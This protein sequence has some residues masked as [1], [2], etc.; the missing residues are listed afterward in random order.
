MVIEVVGWGQLLGDSIGG[1][2]G[3]L[4]QVP[5]GSPLSRHHPS[6]LANLISAQSLPQN[7]TKFLELQDPMELNAILTKAP[8]RG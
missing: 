5:D 4:L 2:A 7:V 1:H 6:I 8:G 3:G